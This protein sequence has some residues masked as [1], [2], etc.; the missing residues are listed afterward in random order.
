MLLKLFIEIY[1]DK[2]L[3][4][5]LLEAFDKKVKSDKLNKSEEN[6][7]SLKTLI[8]S[9]CDEAKNLVQNNSYIFNSFYGLILCYLSDYDNNLYNSLK[10]SLFKENKNNI[11]QILLDY[12]N[13]LK[14]ELILN[15]EF[16]NSFVKYS[17]D[18]DYDTFIYKC[19]CCITDVELFLTAIDNN[20]KTIMNIMDKGK[21]YGPIEVKEIN[22]N[23]KFDI[24]KLIK[25]VKKI[26]DFSKEQNKLLVYFN[27]KFWDN[28]NI[29]DTTMNNI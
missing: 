8:N 15:E 4:N 7:E 21:K 6:L 9:I 22:S 19:L 1:K 24:T 16:C 3:C 18:K 29:N 2:E 26:I 5:L 14:N 10:D 17:A 12:R 25:L 27:F 13:Y 20:K 28:M 11:F 23:M